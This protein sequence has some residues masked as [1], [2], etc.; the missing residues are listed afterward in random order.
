MD[1]YF[2]GADMRLTKR[3]TISSKT[4]YPNA[5]EF[6]SYLEKINTIED[7]YTQINAHAVQ[8]HC[9]LKGVLT[10]PLVKES[11]A[12]TTT[13][14]TTTSWACLDFDGLPKGVS[15][16]SIL[17]MFPGF[18]GVDYVIQYS[19]SH[20]IMGQSDKTKAH[21][22]ILFDSPVNPALLKHMFAQL[23]VQIEALKLSLGLTKSQMALSYILDPTVAQ[24][25]KLIYI[26]PPECTPPSL[27]TLSTRI[28]LV[29]RTKRYA[30]FFVTALLPPEALKTQVEQRIN[31]L[32]VASGLETRK[33]FVYRTDTESGVQFMSKPDKG[34]VTDTKLERG[35]AYLNLNGGD[36]FAYYHPEDNPTYLYNFKSEPVYKLSEIAPEYFVIA[37]A[38]AAA[39]KKAAIQSPLTAIAGATQNLYFVFRDMKS[40]LYY[41]GI[42]N[43]ATQTWNL[44]R[45][46]SEK[47]LADFMTQYGQPAPDIIPIWD[48]VF[49]PQLAPLDVAQRKI[50]LYT[51]SPYM[52]A[53]KARK[54]PPGDFST[55]KKV[56]W[57]VVGSDQVTYEHFINWLAFIIQ[58]KNRTQT[59]WLFQGVH[60]T[61]KGTLIHRILRPL[62][63]EQN[64]AYLE[65]NQLEDRFN[66]RM[67]NS[68]L[69][70]IDEMSIE[71][72]E[73]GSKILATLKTMITEPMLTIRK[74][75]AAGY[76]VNNFNN[77]V[78]CSNSNK[79]VTIEGTD[80][81]YNVGLFQ[82]T[83]IKL[84]DEEVDELI[85]AELESF[86]QFLQQYPLNEAKARRVLEN[87]ARR[88]IKDASLTSIDKISKNIIDGDLEE[89][90]SYIVDI[91]QAQGKTMITAQMYKELMHN[92]LLNEWAS[93]SRE[94]LQLIF[95][96][97]V[98]DIP[99]SPAKFS[100]F[101]NHHNI[102]IVP[103]NRGSATFRGM[104]INW[105]T[106]TDPAWYADAKAEI[107]ASKQP[108]LRSVA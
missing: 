87:A 51:E 59:A 46:T 19:A 90:H 49:D 32:R 65:M 72:L 70:F 96:H 20:G 71:D 108:K 3:F 38:H 29:K 22:F 78:L 39:L 89:L 10:R 73:H 4:S 94:E 28:L 77:Y 63:G 92:I 103:V 83:P 12:G 61:G 48:L 105:S 15:I 82:T 66:E 107:I 58:K 79:Q 84:S 34:I 35:F 14:L 21:V 27:D 106:G 75:R 25:D 45:A 104:K 17:D 53:A 41:N 76:L 81:R 6:T 36:S 101:C 100:R 44:A 42:Y 91:N 74:M 55:I 24:N 57:S 99:T 85:P 50:N 80:R 97:T 67:E 23:N 37:K 18:E 86:T 43:Q 1:M 26:A 56:I 13:P 40:S 98:G 52:K 95:A 11:R 31:E 16:E 8:G 64:T 33:K 93:L 9:L 60:G 68:L 62:L 47:M 5:Y 54:T 69:T 88:D 30:T 2:L 102:K 7:L